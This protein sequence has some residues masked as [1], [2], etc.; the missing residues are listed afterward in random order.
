MKDMPRNEIA[1]AA[2]Y[3]VYRAAGH[4]SPINI[5][6]DL[7]GLKDFLTQKSFS[8]GPGGGAW[9][10]AQ[11]QYLKHIRRRPAG[12]AAAA[13]TKRKREGLQ[14]ALTQV[15]A[16]GIEFVTTLNTQCEDVV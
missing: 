8:R 4:A 7:V 16:C 13:K 11:L 14:P 5:R 3:D 9:Y 2:Y 1:A 6:E 15:V 10:Q 12:S